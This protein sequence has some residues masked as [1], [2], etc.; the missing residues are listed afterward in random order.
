MLKGIGNIQREL[1]FISKSSCN[2]NT[3]YSKKYFFMKSRDI[4]S[5]KDPLEQILQGD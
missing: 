1:L 5:K 2:I 4:I 3:H